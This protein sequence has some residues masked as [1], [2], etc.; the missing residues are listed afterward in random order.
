[1]IFVTERT[2]GSPEAD[3]SWLQIPD[4]YVRERGVLFGAQGPSSAI[5]FDPT[6]HLTTSQ[7][8]FSSA[9]L[10]LSFTYSCV[11]PVLM[12]VGGC[13]CEWMI[14]QGVI[15]CNCWILY[16][17]NDMLTVAAVVDN[18]R[19]VILTLSSASIS[20]TCPLL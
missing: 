11:V 12:L 3:S 18:S 20:A 9:V 2:E 13:G 17:D 6:V 5:P 16:S 10:L 19:L 1:M 4:G 8:Y 15:E 7:V 14:L